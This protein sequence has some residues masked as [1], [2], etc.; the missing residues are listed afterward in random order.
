MDCK[1]FRF[2]FKDLGLTNSSV[3]NL[4]GCSDDDRDF[5]SDLTGKLMA[6]ASEISDIKAE[7]RIFDDVIF[8]HDNKSI[9]VNNHLFSTGNIIYNQVRRSE[10]MAFFM[11]TA[12]EGI[13][14][15]SREAMKQKDHLTGYIYDVMGSEIVEAAA[16]CMQSELES[17]YFPGKNITNR[18]SPGYC[19]W[20]VSQQHELFNLFSNNYCGIRLTDSALMDPVKSVSGIIGIGKDVKRIDYSCGICSMTDCIYRRSRSGKSS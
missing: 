5:I 19:G 12:G 16:D 11:C 20:N 17:C 13:A 18:Y 6:D 4:I 3:V 8:L 15:K 10:Y 1:T 2:D 14:R 9:L 7:Y